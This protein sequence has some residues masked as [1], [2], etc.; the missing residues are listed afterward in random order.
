MRKRFLI[1]FIG[2]LILCVIV[3]MVPLAVQC[4]SDFIM[5]NFTAVPDSYSQISQFSRTEPIKMFLSLFCFHDI[6]H[7]SFHLI[8]INSKS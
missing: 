3:S 7:V 2:D 1:F 8:N 6:N 4:V 5:Y